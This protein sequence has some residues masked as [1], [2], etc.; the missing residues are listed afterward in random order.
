MSRLSSP[1]QLSLGV[2]TLA[3]SLSAC[4]NRDLV[5][6]NPCIT[7]GVALRVPVTN[8]DKVDLLLVVDN[9]GSMRE[10]QA[11]LAEE[12][13]GLIN[14]LATGQLGDREFPA[15]RD[16]RV[17]VV[18][19]DMGTGGFGNLCPEPMRGDDGVLIRGSGCDS[20]DM[21]FLGFQP[22]LGGDANAFATSVACRAN[23]GTAGCGFEQQ[24]DAMLKAVTP[25]T[26]PIRFTGG[27][28]GN[29]DTANEGFVR[30]DALLAV[31]MLTDEDDCSAANPI[32]FNQDNSA[33][34]QF[35]DPR[36]NLRC[37]SILYG[38]DPTVVHPVQRY[39][40]D[41]LLTLKNPEEI[42]FA[43]IVGIPT[44]LSAEFAGETPNYDLLTG[45]PSPGCTEGCRDPNLVERPQDA[46]AGG[47]PSLL[48][49]SCDQTAAGRGLAFPP[50]R[51]A[52]VARDLDAAGAA[53]VV[54]SICQE[55]FGPAL[56]VVISKIADALSATCLPRPLNQDQTGRVTCEILEVL[57]TE[58]DITSCSQLLDR[59][60]VPS[61]EFAEG[62]GEICVVCQASDAGGAIVDLNPACA[63]APVGGWFYETGTAELAEDCPPDR[64]QRVSFRDGARPVTGSTI[65]LECLTQ[66]GASEGDIAIGTA[67]GGRDATFCSGGNLN[68][69][70][71]ID[72]S[73]VCDARFNTCQQSCMNDADCVARGLGGFR[74]IDP[75]AVETNGEGPN[76]VC[77]NPTCSAN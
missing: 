48:V 28:R 32:I 21:P 55:D 38:N 23:L 17:G 8:V 30:D 65:R 42:V 59:G 9:S 22:D 50:V 61:G 7:S 75:D 10:E 31:I 51:I 70:G 71:D 15:V 11:S 63:D 6:L 45:D 69:G 41:G 33:M 19:T 2:L 76:R 24:L 34:P 58:G 27:T 56:G 35:N 68:L 36:L 49:P 64:Q 73:L 5:P 29:N 74:C 40:A 3:L 13:P 43:A 20:P 1:L 66:S 62:G 14:A 16:L 39:V 46:A 37:S 77:V 18:S 25:S 47:D 44:E 4:G 26:S 12:I 72:L 52:R 60:R 54:Q 57:P 67:C 53:S